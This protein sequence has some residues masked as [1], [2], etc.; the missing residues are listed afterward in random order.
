MRRL[1]YVLT[2]AAVVMALPTLAMASNQEIAE[3][4]AVNLRESGQLEGYKIGVKYQD[5]TAWLRG[6]VTSQHQMNAALRVAMQS[7]GVERVVN[8]LT[9]ASPGKPAG[10]K[11]KLSMD[12]LLGGPLRQMQGATAPERRTSQPWGNYERTAASQVTA[13][14]ARLQSV[15]SRT[16]KASPVASSFDNTSAIP[17]LAIAQAESMEI[18]PAPVAVESSPAGAEA[19]MVPV[20]RPVPVAYTQGGAPAPQ[21]V[22][23][24]GAGSAPACYDQPNLPNYAWPSYAAYPNYAALTYPKKY[25]PAAWPYI[26]PFYP[27]PQVPL[28]WRKV[29]LEWHDGWWNLDFDDGTARGPFS[30]LFR[31]HK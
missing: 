3:Q 22:T 12:N 11:Q 8:N 24:V 7:E 15:K 13:T 20:G 1:S 27:Y 30:G 17:T 26:G 4:I 18:P 9:V 5:G 29:T 23:P 21:Y 10:S 16:P 31:P 28:G 2:V 14:A 19:D 25:S 6:Q